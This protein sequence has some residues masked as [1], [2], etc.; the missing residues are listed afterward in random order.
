MHCRCQSFVRVGTGGEPAGGGIPPAAIASNA[1]TFDNADR[2]AVAPFVGAS[3]ARVR[4]RDRDPPAVDRQPVPIR[5][6]LGILKRVR[7]TPMPPASYLAGLLGSAVANA[8]VQMGLVVAIG[9][10]AY[11]VDWPHN[12]AELVGFTALGVVCFGSL[13]I[14]ANDITIVLHEVPLDNWGIRGGK[15]ASEVDLGFNVNV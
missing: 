5:R 1:W 13:G 8:F 11:G 15:P 2:Y 7:G 10:I 9:H 3:L 4:C 12:W 6:E 14:D